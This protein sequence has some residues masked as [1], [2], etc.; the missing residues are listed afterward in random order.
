MRTNW[1]SLS[2]SNVIRSDLL[3]VWEG[4]RMLLSLKIWNIC[5]TLRETAGVTTQN[6][7]IM[8]EINEFIVFVNSIGIESEQYS[9]WIGNTATTINGNMKCHGGMTIGLL[10]ALQCSICQGVCGSLT[11]RRHS[12]APTEDP[13]NI[14]V[15]WS[16]VNPDR[17]SSHGFWYSDHRL[18]IPPASH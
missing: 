5:L 8:S 1:I 4:T 13:L 11:S 6:D 2:Y 17:D 3:E 16:H 10:T 18:A 14:N 9:D 15:V 12:W 7:I